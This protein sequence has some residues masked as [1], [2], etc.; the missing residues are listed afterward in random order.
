MRLAD[1]QTRS[2]LDQMVDSRTRTIYSGA[3]GN[4]SRMARNASSAIS[5]R[6]RTGYSARKLPLIAPRESRTERMSDQV[7]DPGLRQC[8]S[9]VLD[10]PHAAADTAPRSAFPARSSDLMRPQGN[11]HGASKPQMTSES[12][13]WAKRL[14]HCSELRGAVMHAGTVG[15]ITVSMRRAWTTPRP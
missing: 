15:P 1:P 11:K 8:F 5:D 10:Q 6:S 13:L 9:S 7:L 4:S 14:L 3:Q 12:R 2:S